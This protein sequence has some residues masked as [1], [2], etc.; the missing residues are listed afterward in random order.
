MSYE[1]TFNVMR[2]NSVTVCDTGGWNLLKRLMK[3]FAPNSDE[4]PD[5]RHQELSEGEMVLIFSGK[6]ISV[7]QRQR[8]SDSHAS[9]FIYVEWR[10]QRY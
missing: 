10:V 7:R 6:K 8:L 5:Q 1:V 3:A 4:S 2:N 9:V